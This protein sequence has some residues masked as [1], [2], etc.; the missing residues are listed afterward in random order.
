MNEWVC[1]NSLKGYSGSPCPVC[2][3][4]PCLVVPNEPTVRYCSECGGNLHHWNDLAR[5]LRS[6]ITTAPIGYK[7]I[8]LQAAQDIERYRGVLQRMAEN[9]GVINDYPIWARRVLAGKPFEP[10]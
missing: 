5:A 7:P 1:P 9:Y 10:L 8:F 6:F 4:G 3:M 2:H